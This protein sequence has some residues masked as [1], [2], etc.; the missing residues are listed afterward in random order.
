M[1]QVADRLR[2]EESLLQ[3]ECHASISQDRQH[4][5]KIG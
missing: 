1:A 5:P 4:S 2:E 3:L